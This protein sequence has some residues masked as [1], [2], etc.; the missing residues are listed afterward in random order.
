MGTGFNSR[1]KSGWSVKLITYLNLILRIRMSGVVLLLSLLACMDD[2]GTTVLMVIIIII[3]A[4]C[5]A[6][7]DSI[8][9]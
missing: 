2:T 6:Q 1:G 8:L 4:N 5:T 3:I 7:E 9:T